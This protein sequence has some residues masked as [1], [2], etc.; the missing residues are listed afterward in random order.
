MGWC[1]IGR[2]GLVLV[3][4]LAAIRPVAAQRKPEP[5]ASEGATVEPAGVGDEAG[6]PK[7]THAGKPASE[8]LL[9]ASLD[10]SLPA[11]SDGGSGPD[12][13]R[14]LRPRPL[15]P[16]ERLGLDPGG[17]PEVRLSALDAQ[18]LKLEDLEA[19]G[20]KAR[21]R[22]S[23]GRDLDLGIEKGTW[24]EVPGAG[25]VWVMDVV[26]PEAVGLRVHLAEV[27]LPLGAELWVYAP[28]HPESASGPYLGRG[29]L[30]DGSFWTGTV[31]GERARIELWAPGD[32]VS[33]A[34][35]PPRITGLQHLY[36]DPVAEDPS[37]GTCHNDVTCSASWTNVSHGVARIS[38]VEN[39]NGFLCS[40]SFLNPQ[41]GDL[42]PYVLTSNTCIATN[43]VAQTT[44][45]FW[46]YQT[47]S[48][49]AT[50]PTLSSVPKS[51]VATLAVTSTASDSTILMEE[52]ALP[53][54]L[55]W[56]G[57]DANTIATGQA[58]ALIHHPV[59]GAKRISFGTK[60]TADSSVCSTGSPNFVRM[61]YSD[62]ASESGSEGAPIF[63]SDTQ[64]V[65]GNLSCG[66]ATCASQ[67]FDNFGA[68]AAFYSGSTTVQTLLAGG[69]DDVLE[70]NDTC[71]TA[72][73]VS[74]GTF[75]NRVVKYQ[76]DDWFKISVPAG[77]TLSATVT[78]TDANG[79]LDLELFSSCGGAAVA[80]STGSS[81]VE[82]FVFTNSGA[83]ANFLLHVFL[84]DC[85]TR[86][87]YTMVLSAV[88][89][90]DS[91][92][93]PT[94]IPG[95]A[96][97]FNPSPYATNQADATASEPQESCEVSNVGVSNVVW[98]SFT[99]CGSGTVT[100]DTFGSSY[101]TVLSMFTGTCA[102]GSQVACSD[103][104][105]G[106]QARLLS[107]PV[108]A[109]TTYLIKVA[110]YNATAGGGTLDFNF[111]YTPTPPAHDAC[112]AAVVIP[113]NATAFNPTP[114]CTVGATVTAGDPAESC[115]F[116]TNS[117]PV[118]YSFTP[119]TDGHITVDTN[120]SGYDTV[121][122]LFHGTCAAPVEIAC[123]D[124]SGTG[125]DSQLV[126]V[127]VTGGLTYLIKVA[128]FG[129][130]DGGTLDFNFSYVPSFVPPDDTCATGTVIPGTTQ[131][132]TPDSYCT[133]GANATVLEPQES[134][135]VG[136]VGVSNTVWYSFRAC[137]N[138]TL[139][140]DTNGSG[141]DTVLALFSGTC[142]SAVQVACDDD[143]GTGSNSQ[144][145][146]VPVTGG[147]QYFIKI[148]DYGG[149][150]GGTLIWHFTYNAAVPA[151]D[152][153]A[154]ATL[155]PA[156]SFQDT[157]CTITSSLQASEPIEACGVAPRDHSV[158][159]RFVPA[160]SGPITADT[161]GSDF[162]TVLS[163]FSGSCASPVAMLCNDDTEGR[164]SL[165][166]GVPLTAGTSYLIKVDS[167]GTDVGGR[168]DF[169][170]LSGE[171]PAGII[172]ARSLR[173]DK[174]TGSGSLA[175]GSDLKLTWGAS[176]KTTD[177]DFAIYEGTIGNY[178]SHAARFC[179]T[180]GATSKTFT[181]SVGSKYYLVV[182][183]N[184]SF[185]GSYGPASSGERPPG[186][187]AC[188]PQSI[189][190]PCP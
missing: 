99:P 47:A 84:S 160:A 167:S 55:F 150:N 152:N 112:G 92:A 81:N 13:A 177:N 130:P 91:C 111:A 37:L 32:A 12:G 123:D 102:A 190:A 89:P 96:T 147:T 15:L 155:L 27:E 132:L 172:A 179:T 135:E 133:M 65:Y 25:R 116:T 71:A 186:V 173:V 136:G 140:L 187:N 51:S 16:S 101:D 38:F 156:G 163:L 62:G 145:V 120:G 61:N 80:S 104:A 188:L 117:N 157:Y 75:T 19:T 85:D 56:P 154:A 118:Y 107:V 39:G 21:L 74:E 184:G 149:P 98:Y 6:L 54:G 87:S 67:T 34:F 124:D 108:T 151:N 88:L 137:G 129:N 159:Y 175:A 59:G 30:E 121:L 9:P 50:P 8:S 114:F 165:L 106:T 68:L 58:S 141:Y 168:L 174:S 57:L 100:I 60:A 86:N 7:E 3:V 125:L 53:C 182:P 127:P 20:A 73:T 48:C 143:S 146:N 33:G 18:A 66:P 139:S 180:A 134:C 22:I 158:W 162:D 45:F 142:G 52:G 41:N 94:V 14:S 17:A 77:G 119:C 110:D 24:L 44:Q 105:I 189:A 64:R 95:S 93:V 82:S 31:E 63:R 42:T 26:S 170:F 72:L 35:A 185:E 166:A 11:W 10:P 103:N 40:A 90:N 83:T 97:S 128:D 78:F 176:C 144:L 29:P 70:P 113:E 109:G 23:V 43:T 5:S 181:P 49:N 69:S 1:A 148:S 79:D 28:G 131:S 76:H 161:F 46:L 4:T 2:R 138:G 178:S 122:S 183:V 169:N 171:V 164:Q 126:N 153:C 36:R 115:G